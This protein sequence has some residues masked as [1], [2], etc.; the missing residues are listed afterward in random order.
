MRFFGWIS[1]IFS[2]FGGSR[3]ETAD[4][5]NEEMK[6]EKQIEKEADVVMN[7]GKPDEDINV[8]EDGNE[9]LVDE[10]LDEDEKNLPCMTN[11]ELSWLQF[12]ERVLNEAGNPGVPLAERLSFASIYQS[13]LDEFFMVRVGTLMVQMRSKE[14]IRENKTNMTSKQQISAILK[15]VKKLELKKALIYE[16]L[17][18][19]LEPYD[20][21]V[22]NFSRLSKGEGDFLEKYF[23]AHIAPFLSPI[24]VGK[25]HPFP[26]LENKGLYA[27]VVLGSA[28]K[29]KKKIG[30]VP[31]S[32]SVFKRLIEIPTRPGCF[33]LSEELILHFVSKLYPKYTVEAKSIMRIT[34]NADIEEA[35]IVDEDMDYRHSMEKLIKKRTRLNPVRCELSRELDKKTKKE[36]ADCLGIDTDYF[37]DVRT[38]LDLKF[39]FSL[40][41]YLKEKNAGSDLFYVKRSPRR[42]PSLN[43]RDKILDQVMKKDVMLSYPYESMRPFIT[44]LREA[45]V[46]PDVVSIKM[47][48]YRV[49]DQSKIVEALMDA[50]ENGKEVVVL[51]ELRARFDEANN[52]E[53]SRKLEDAGCH[54]LYG[55]G[56]YKVHSKL[57]LIT[58]KTVFGYT[59]ISQIGTGNYN[60]KT[61]EL[62]ADLCLIT[63]RQDIGADVANVFAA[64]QQGELVEHTDKLMVAPLCLQNRITAYIDE[65]I[66]KAKNGGSGYV[67][68]KCNS[69][70][71]KVIMDKLVEA[72]QAGVKIELII[73]GIC[74]IKPKVEG[75]TDNITEI[76]IVGRYLEHARIYRFGSGRE[77]KIFISSAD[78]MT[79]NTTRRVEVAVPILDEE[80]RNRVRNI[81]DTQMKDDEKGKEQD[82]EGNY[83][84]RNINM[85]KLNSQELFFEQAY[86]AEK[87]LQ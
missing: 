71:D 48:L 51:V 62:Y 5:G 68:I 42:T 69:M 37:V 61:A 28:K 57:C 1:R 38:P 65:E 26:F 47:T 6:R 20:I 15:E 60:E 41:N 46:D 22:I 21:R 73:R 16:Q 14:T 19:E 85:P 18:G 35:E 55:L 4:T 23:Y 87:T 11:R 3:T 81:F 64:L 40:Q 58:R 80:L 74:C 29:G 76:S 59:Y 43:S 31:C 30:I 25:Q 44:M 53:M 75:L 12:N 13:N 8:T 34:R 2:R 27:V 63:A 84:D 24:V 54:I 77:E 70:T 10:K 17:M 36:L 86:Q 45:A 9:N 49:A 56:E 50:A 72:S 33:M 67:G 83:N 78:M 7:G 82:A 52:I 66:A 39:V 32:N 79:R